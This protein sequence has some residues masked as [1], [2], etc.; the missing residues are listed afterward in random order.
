[1]G[2][3]CPRS[4][5]VFDMET[6]PSSPANAARITD[7][8]RLDSP[9]LDPNEIPPALAESMLCVPDRCPSLFP[10]R[11]CSPLRRARP[12]GLPSSATA[13]DGSSTAEKAAKT[14]LK[15][16]AASEGTT[17]HVVTAFG[18]ERTELIAS[19]GD[20]WIISDAEKAKTLAGEVAAQLSDGNVPIEHF[21]A[22]GKP[23]I[24]LINHAEKY[25]A[26]LIVV[27]NKNMQGLGRVLGSVAN[28]VAHNAPCDVYVVKT[29]ED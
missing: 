14:A 13:D 2:A 16:A 29:H 15:L 20:R 19:G 3:G 24:A 26:N 6:P 10:Q 5:I 8:Y 18:G 21:A 1:M 12:A 25:G 27:G 23:R 17:L 11:T 7:F 4:P 9:V 22:R 28:T